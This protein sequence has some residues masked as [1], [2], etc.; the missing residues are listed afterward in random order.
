LIAEGVAN[1]SLAQLAIKD[2]E[3]AALL[4][5]KDKEIAAA[6]AAQ[7]VAELERA[8]IEKEK[9]AIALAY[10]AKLDELKGM[11]ATDVVLGM[12]PYVAPGKVVL[13]A[14]EDVVLD[15]LAARFSL[16]R[17]IEGERDFTLL[18]EEKKGDAKL[19]I[20]NTEC[21]KENAA[22]NQENESLK[23]FR[24]SCEES[25]K[26]VTEDRDAWKT[27]ASRSQRWEVIER[28]VT[29]ASVVVVVL[30]VLKVF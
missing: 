11:P 17:F 12:Q 10:Q 18:A 15:Q 14:N 22:L 29:L 2:K 9:D 4:K 21:K 30:K 28:Y 26:K 6:K 13:L 8:K 24:L 20:M 23:K 7:L 19:L 27:T 16:K 25:V 3:V 5:V 1:E